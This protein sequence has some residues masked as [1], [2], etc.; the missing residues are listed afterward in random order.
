MKAYEIY[1]Y[2]HISVKGSQRISKRILPYTDLTF[3]LRGRLR[4]TVNSETYDL[5]AGD[6]VIAQPGDEES[7][8][9]LDEAAEYV[10]FNFNSEPLSFP[11][12]A[13]GIITPAIKSIVDIY[14]AAH[15][16]DR[17]D[18]TAEKCLCMLNY[19]LL[20]L[21]D[22]RREKGRFFPKVSRIVNRG[23]TIPLSL[24]D[25]SREL[26]VTKE[27]LA[28]TF[29]KECG[30]TVSEYV[31]EQK[32][33]LARSLIESEEMPICRIAEYLGYNNYNYFCRV[34]KK[35]FG[36]SPTKMRFRD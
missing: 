3:V 9:A 30:K 34:F 28:T 23:I 31:N 17:E 22:S 26:G 7:R 29:K 36:I 8:D 18:A 32:M 10:S 24:S 21:E 12:F 6:A 35:T 25:I 20:E 13:K 19:I 16:Y 14:P 5:E 1:H 2:C 27:Y 33:S 11:V 4:Y 15:M